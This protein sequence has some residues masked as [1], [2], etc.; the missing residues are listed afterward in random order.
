MEIIIVFACFISVLGSSNKNKWN[1]YYI[2]RLSGAKYG[3]KI[4]EIASLEPKI[5]FIEAQTCNCNI[6]CSNEAI[7]KI[8]SPF[9]APDSLLI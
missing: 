3:E 8:F 6:L 2:S 5:G 1:S 9:L 4:F 7:S